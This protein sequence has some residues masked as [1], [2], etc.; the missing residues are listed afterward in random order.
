MSSEKLLCCEADA[1][2]W[3]CGHE[4]FDEPAAGPGSDHDE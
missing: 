1:D 2:A 3:H 4:T